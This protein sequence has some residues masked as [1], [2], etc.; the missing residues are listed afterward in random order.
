MSL[1]EEVAEAVPMEMSMIHEDDEDV[2]LKTNA[3]SHEADIRRRADL[4]DEY[5][6][7]KKEVLETVLARPGD[8]MKMVLTRPSDA[9]KTVFT[10]PG[11][12]DCTSMQSKC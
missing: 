8:T 3:R 2:M 4:Q 10:R 12:T 5:P 11:D 9:M 1:R 6:R 7:N